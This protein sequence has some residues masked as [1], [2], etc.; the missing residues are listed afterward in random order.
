MYNSRFN[1]T[2]LLWL[3]KNTDKIRKKEDTMGEYVE[4][5]GITRRDFLWIMK[6]A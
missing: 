1:L 3:G 4:K 2:R 5:Q 6:S